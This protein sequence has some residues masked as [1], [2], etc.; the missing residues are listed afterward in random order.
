MRLIFWGIA[1]AVGIAAGATIGLLHTRSSSPTFPVV[2]A[3]AAPDVTWAAGKLQAPDFS[4][5]DQNG[6]PVSLARFRGRPVIVTF[7]DPLCRNLCPTEAR[8]LGNVEKSFPAGQRPA[9]VSVSVNKWGN[10]RRILLQDVQKWRL[11][12]DWHW[13]VGPGAAL[14]RVWQAWKIG[15]VATSKTVTGVTVHEITHTEAS[16]VVDS[17]GDQRALFLF[18]FRAADVVRAIRAA[19]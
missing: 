9:I 10:A 6:K 12:V 15:V 5:S 17:R 16:F 8:I 19:G 7:I 2:T 14:A 3:P 18:P 1:L 13:A 11:P 4:L